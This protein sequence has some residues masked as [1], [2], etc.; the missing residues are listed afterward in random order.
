MSQPTVAV[1]DVLRMT[2][3]TPKHGL[4]AIKTLPGHQKLFFGTKK[5]DPDFGVFCS[6]QSSALPWYLP[7]VY[8]T[9][10]HQSGRH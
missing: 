9:D 7:I 1:F 3:D 6:R 5:E 2:E 10:T 4:F 8:L